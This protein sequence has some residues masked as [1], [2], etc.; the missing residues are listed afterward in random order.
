[1]QGQGVNY[2]A[3]ILDDQKVQ[4]LDVTGPG[5]DRHMRRCRA[6]GIGQLV[7]VGESSI[8]PQT[9]ARQFGEGKRTAV[10]DATGAA[11]DQLDFFGRAAEPRGGRCPDL[12][13]QQLRSLE[14][15]R[16]AQDRRA[17]GE[18]TVSLVQIGGRAM[19]HAHLVELDV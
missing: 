6:I 13:E 15:R 4:Q 5:V 11:I 19:Q 1:M 12:F 14:H 10:A 18:C 17:R 9:L 7:V 8:D 2:A 16:A 3:D